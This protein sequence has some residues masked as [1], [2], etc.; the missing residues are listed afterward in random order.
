ME[1]KKENFNEK[2]K[3]EEKE[4]EELE[5]N[6]E[7]KKE[8][9]KKGQ[10][11]KRKKL[12]NLKQ[13]NKKEEVEKIVSLEDTE[14][15]N[16]NGKDL[17][18]IDESL[19]TFI[20]DKVFILNKKLKINLNFLYKKICKQERFDK[21]SIFYSG[22]CAYFSF[23]D[24]LYM[25]FYKLI[26]VEFNC[27][28][29]DE[30]KNEKKIFNICSSYEIMEY[31]ENNKYNP[32]IEINNEKYEYKYLFYFIYNYKFE[33]LDKIILVQDY[34]N[35][36]DYTN[37][38]PMYIFPREKSELEPNKLSNFFDLYFKFETK[39]N[40]EYWKS[41]QRDR[42]MHIIFF[43]RE[44]KNIYCFKICGPPG[45]GKSMTLFLISK[46][47]NNFL[48]YNLKAI[49][50]INNDNIKI[51][52]ILTESCKYLD[53]N[54]N[55]IK[56]LSSILNNN[57]LN[58][59]FLCLKKIIKFLIENKILSVIILD[60]F[61]SDVIDKKQ[62]DEIYLMI[63]KQVSKYVKLLICSSTNDK[64][65]RKECIKSWK[66]N[67][68]FLEQFNEKNQNY[69]F[70]IDELFNINQNSNGNTIYDKVLIKF[71]FIPKYKNIF[72]YLKEKVDHTNKLSNDLKTI[73]EQVKTKLVELY[74]KINENDKSDEIIKMKMV[75]SL[76]YLDLHIGEKI[77]YEKL[78]EFLGICSFKYY[79]FK[80]EDKHFS[81]DYNFSYMSEIV[82]EVIDTYLEDFYKYKSN[83]KHSGSANSDFFELFSGKSLKKG[84]LELP[85][86]QN[87]IYVKVDEIME[88]KSF[89]K[90]EID[91]LFKDEIYDYLENYKVKKEKNIEIDKQLKNINLMESL[92]DYINY[93]SRNIEYYKWQYLDDIETEYEILGNKNIGDMSAFIDQNNQRGKLLDLVYVYGPKDDKKL[94]GFKMKAYDEKSSNNNKFNPTKD[95]IKKELQPMIVN[96]KYLMNMNIKSWH[97]IVIFLYNKKKEEEKQYF[98]NIVET[99]KINGLE[100]IFYEPF[101][102]KFYDRNLELMTKFKPN[103]FS[104]LDINLENILPINIMNYY[105]INEYMF[106]FS[107]YILINKISDIKYIEE[108]LNSLLNK[109][110]NR[111][112]TLSI[113]NEENIKEIKNVLNSI[114]DN[115]KLKFEFKSIKF[116]GAYNFL[117][118]ICIQ[119]PKKDYFFLISSKEKDIYY[120]VFN[121]ENLTEKYYKYNIRLKIDIFD[122]KNISK[123]IDKINPDSIIKN[124]DME[125]KFYVFK[126]FEK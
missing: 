5:E 126:I 39:S 21:F 70:Y 73:K 57:R 97:Y 25:F 10:Q 45:I 7:E 75:E 38:K 48:Y 12:K 23:E 102:K 77:E 50:D 30:S 82:N 68:F 44:K 65:I 103:E 113:K 62:Y 31:C 1:E 92:K 108:G 87:I 37:E 52:N 88:M 17:I 27:I 115:I 54:E 16:E 63:S 61:K 84:I 121:K 78:T 98:K 58:S 59:F 74:T 64:E 2:E 80:F 35:Y 42:F 94:I 81:F 22:Y 110:R 114:L 26:P 124:M 28:Y 6:S 120:I 122:K 118:E 24:L 40:F 105:D 33:N 20:K 86:S 60:Q 9:N 76:R 15:I 85:E 96:I 93:N 89:A 112:E 3:S 18:E 56:Q 117:K 13:N 101:E 71:N 99:C 32:Y 19:K 83:D 11:L 14:K 49:R 72:K 107:Q 43:Y 36:D 55:Q 51:Q 53:L 123:V 111:S 106:Q 119:M 41:E 29:K 79:R 47:Y 91:K 66:S 67:I 104:N 100:F 90:D 125:E 34:R 46:Y 69:Y 8:K 4:E 116:I 109:K 95:N